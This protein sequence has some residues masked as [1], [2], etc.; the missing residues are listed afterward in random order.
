MRP[1]TWLVSKQL[2]SLGAFHRIFSELQNLFIEE[3][4][5]SLV[6]PGSFVANP[7]K[8]SAKDINVVVSQSKERFVR[9]DPGLGSQRVTNCIQVC[10]LECISLLENI[11]ERVQGAQFLA[12]DIFQISFSVKN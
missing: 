6:E 12:L 5:L 4:I 11:V 9:I 7:L 3:I 8:G 10:L 1:K 2:G